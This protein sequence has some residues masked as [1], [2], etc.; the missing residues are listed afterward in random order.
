MNQNVLGGPNFNADDS[1]HEHT[2]ENAEVPPFRDLWISTHQS[3]RQSLV[4]WREA[5][6]IRWKTDLA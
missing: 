5:E 1:K 3:A 4:R 2:Q 6:A